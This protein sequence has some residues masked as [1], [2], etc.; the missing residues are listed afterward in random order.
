MRITH[1]INVKVMIK[2][3]NQHEFV[4]KVGNLKFFKFITRVY[5]P[6]NHVNRTFSNLI[7]GIAG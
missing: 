5:L 6:I 3:I 1:N 4:E 7:E 2:T